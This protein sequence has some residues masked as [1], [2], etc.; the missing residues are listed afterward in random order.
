MQTM[1][2]LPFKNWVHY[3]W[4]F[5]KNYNEGNLELAIYDNYTFAKDTLFQQFHCN[6]L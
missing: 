3:F 5:K 6:K 4:Y 2:Q 1:G